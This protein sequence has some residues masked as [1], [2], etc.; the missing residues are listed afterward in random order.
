MI[1]NPY[2]GTLV[3]YKDQGFLKLIS[4]FIYDFIKRD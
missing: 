4:N 1:M 2:G 3:F